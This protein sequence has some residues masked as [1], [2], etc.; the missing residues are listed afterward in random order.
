VC[1]PDATMPRRQSAQALCEQ[2]PNLI[3]TESSSR[4]TGHVHHAPPS[5]AVS[6]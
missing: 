5:E 6:G 3:T 4:H 2:E 1:R